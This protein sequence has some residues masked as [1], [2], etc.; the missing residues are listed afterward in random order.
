M[1][2]KMLHQLRQ[3]VNLY[4]NGTYLKIYLKCGF[5]CCDM[6]NPLNAVFFGMDIGKKSK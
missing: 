6:S 3:W 4:F 5:I 1:I 2:K